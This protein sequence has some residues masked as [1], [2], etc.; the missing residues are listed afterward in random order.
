VFSTGVNTLHHRIV[1]FG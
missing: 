1:V